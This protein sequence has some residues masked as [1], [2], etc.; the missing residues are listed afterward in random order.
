MDF[1]IDN[2]KRF[3]RG[4]KSD[5]ISL[6]LLETKKIDDLFLLKFSQ[7]KYQ[8]SKSSGVKATHA[9]PFPTPTCTASTTS[10][11]ANGGRSRVAACRLVCIT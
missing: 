1:S 11:S 10:P 7:K 2:H 6:F 8:L 3:S 4:A 5:K 9:S